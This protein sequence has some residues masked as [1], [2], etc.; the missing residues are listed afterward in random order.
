MK[1]LLKP[2]LLM[3]LTLLLA[4]A[5]LPRA[6]AQ[7]SEFKPAVVISVASI[8]SIMEDVTYL[9]D[10][11]GARENATMAK[12][13]V[14]L[15]TAGVDPKRPSGAYLTF[16]GPEEPV[17]V[18]FIPVT[19]LKGLL[20]IH[21]GSLGAPEDEGDGLL[22]IDGPNGMPIY[23]KEVGGWAFASQ[24]KGMLASTPADP[25]VLLGGLEKEYT[26]AARVSVTNIPAEL[27]AM[28]V[29]QMKS[30]IDEQLEDSA[31]GEN[32]ELVESVAKNNVKQ[33]KQFI[34]DSDV[35]EVGW[36]IDSMAKST[37]IDFSMTAQPGTKLAERMAASKVTK[38]N[39]SGFI[40]PNAAA[41]L[42]FAG[43]ATDEDIA[44]WS[45]VLDSMDKQASKSIDEDSDLKS[46]ED[47]A[48][49]KEIVSSLIGVLRKTAEGGK[50]EGGATV[51]LSEDGGLTVAAGGRIA[52]PAELE[53]V[54]RKTVELAKKEP[55]F[56]GFKF[57][58]DSYKGVSFHTMSVPLDDADDD[59]RGVVGENLD[60]AIGTGD[61]S[62]YL[63]FGK[64]NIAT[65]KK[66]IDQSAVG[67]GVDQPPFQFFVAL[68]PILK[69][70]AK[71]G[72]DPITGMIAAGADKI[73]GNDRISITSKPIE[74]GASSRI[75]IDEGVLKL[76]GEV[77]KTFGGMGGGP[78]GPIPGAF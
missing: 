72:D 46:D 14:G 77:G 20:K 10:V 59:V 4:A 26:V 27:R 54:L 29:E 9:A 15:M 8:E 3:A 11:A 36:A 56:P 34:E 32:R 21:E 51:L 62:V 28:A 7:Q 12:G 5:P 55:D 74:N 25:A 48:A 2:A 63:A 45:M 64:N 18:V 69:F 41:A 38:S 31:D 66:I 68:A 65:L 60:I 53:R 23:L 24:D 67:V 73:A 1:A 22:R 47:R 17:A 76:L 40:L 58:A 19:D 57:D 43:K 75:Q 37:Y 42:L 52:D 44:Q 71:V 13:M 35:I 50:L 16:N 61:N 49:A 78:G 70:A 6:Q 39:Y 33:M 30:K